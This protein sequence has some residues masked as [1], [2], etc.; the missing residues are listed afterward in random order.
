ME[1]ALAPHGRR[2]LIDPDYMRFDTEFHIAV[3]AA[4]R[5]R[6]LTRATE[7]IRLRAER[8]AQ[9]PAGHGDLAPPSVRRARGDRSPRSRPA[10]PTRPR[11]PPSCTCST[12]TGASARCWRRSAAAGGRR[13]HEPHAEI[14]AD[15]TNV[16][17]RLL[18]LA[19]PNVERGEGV[20][21]YTTDGRE[22]LDA[23]SGGAMVACLGH[24]ASEIVDA[25]ARAGGA[26]S[27]TST[28][29]TSRTSRRSGWPSACSTWPRRRWRA[30]ASSPA[31]RRRTR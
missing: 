30:S 19:Y 5:N 24:G 20:R 27:R 17:P 4:T 8:R 29:T 15:E 31:A 16:F 14:R 1:R 6:Y 28:T 13:Q 2:P 10:T 11:R 9:P 18:D 23:C 26:V 7:E 25:A 21:L 3:A 12:A 22:I